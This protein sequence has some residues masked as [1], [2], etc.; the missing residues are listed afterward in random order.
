MD[1]DDES[2]AP[3]PPRREQLSKVPSW[4]MLGFVLGAAC[5][6]AWPRQPGLRPTPT[7]TPAVLRKAPPE[8]AHPPTIERAKF[9]ESVFAEWSRFAVWED[10]LTEVAFISAETNSFSEHFEV[11][12]SG[13][14]Y[15]F[16][17]IPQFTR[18]V[19]THGDI[20]NNSPLLFTEPQA[21]RDQW[22]RENS[23]ENLRKFLGAPEPKKP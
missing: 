11:F 2:D 10:E 15:Y 8:P 14:R 21:V 18:P 5:V 23:S 9:F 6:L 7:L 17:S 16:R 13:E 22:L 19:L 12:R 20:P 4:V 3:R 1:M